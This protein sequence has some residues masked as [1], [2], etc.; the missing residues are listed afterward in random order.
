MGNTS[1]EPKSINETNK[2]SQETLNTLKQG[3]I[4][5]ENR[6][7]IA[8]TE[9]NRLEG[10]ADMTNPSMSTSYNTVIDKLNKLQ[11]ELQEE[12]NTLKTLEN[13]YMSLVQENTGSDDDIEQINTKKTKLD[14]QHNKVNTL[15]VEINNYFQNVA[16]PEI[17][18]IKHLL[19][20]KNNFI[21]DNSSELVSVEDVKIPAIYYA[22]N[23]NV[24]II[25]R[26][27]YYWYVVYLIVFLGVIIALYMMGISVG[28]VAKQVEKVPQTINKGIQS[29]L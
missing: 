23:E 19:Q 3:I 11:T 1:S 18:D 29:I 2:K 12:R 7:T 13:E 10:F 4:L 25:E 15:T 17:N 9:T 28:T 16:I 24:H 6:S 22:L 5:L 27:R 14:E 26:M 8:N 21:D 20:E